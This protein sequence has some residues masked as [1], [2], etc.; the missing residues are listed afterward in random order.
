MRRWLMLLGLLCCCLWPVGVHAEELQVKYKADRVEYLKQEDVFRL[1]GNVE[2]QVRDVTIHSQQLDYD[3][4]HKIMRSDTPFIMEQ[5]TKEGKIQTLKGTSFRYDVGLRRVEGEN[6]YLTIPAQAEG[7]EIYIQ[8]DA[9]TAYEDGKRVLFTNG[10]YTTCNHF[11]AKEEGGNDEDPYSIAAVKR[12]ATHYAVQAEVLDFVQNQRVLAWN[13]QILTFENQAFWFPFWYVPLEGPGEIKKPDIDIGQNAVEGIFAKFKGY[14]RWNEYHDGRWY[15]SIIQK[16]GYGLGFQHDW[17]AYPNS[18]TRI[19][20]YGIPVTSDFL[21]GTYNWLLPPT[22]AATSDTTIQ[23]DSSNASTWQN[24]WLNWWSNKFMDHEFEFRHKQLLLPHMESEWLYQD[25]DLYNTAALT[26]SRNP[27]RNFQFDLRDNE[28][29]A[30]DDFSDLSTDLTLQVRQGVTAPQTDSIDANDPSKVYTTTTVAQSQNRSA[31]IAARLDKSNLNLR[32][33][34]SNTTNSTRKET[35]VNDQLTDAPSE[36]FGSGNENW[37]SNLTFS[38]QLD[39]KTKLNTNLIYNSIISGIS[40]SNLNGTLKKTLQPKFSLDQTHDW[41]SISLGYEDFFDLSPEGDSS[42]NRQVKKIPEF[43]LR[44]K[45]FFQDSFPVQLETTIGRYFEQ[46]AVV[47]SS[48]LNEIGRGVF[49]LSLSSKEQDLGLGMKVNY[50]GTSFEQRF[51]QTLDAEYIFTGQVNLKNNLSPFFIP[52]FSYQRSVIDQENNNSPFENFENLGLRQQNILTG[53]LN[54]VNLPEFTLIFNGGY[55]YLNRKYQPIRANITSAIGNQFTLRANGSYTPV[56]VEDKDVGSLLKDVRGNDYVDIYTG[57]TTMVTQDMVGSFIPN[58]GKWG[59]VTLG[60]R[61]RNTP[62]ELYIGNLKTFGLEEGIPNGFEIGNN[63]VFDPEQ[64]RFQAINALLRFK[65]GESWQWHTEVDLVASVQPFTL[66]REG[67][68]EWAGLEIPFTITVRKDLHDFVL[69][70]SWD[71]F[72]QQ[73][74]LNLALL[75][76][77]YSTSDL[78]GNVGSLNQQVNSLNSQ[79][80]SGAGNF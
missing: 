40:S 1:I 39:A 53:S 60:W 49:K 72:Y 64:G 43:K 76:F 58:G 7:Q 15:A 61:W 34:W 59:N 35:F 78:L 77:P 8:G 16:K 42:T 9:M 56:N 29:F 27:Q 62:N 2:L 37:N 69:T 36:Q 79:V 18:I 26:A 21:T 4:R 71:S 50:G 74:N 23:Q 17:I 63:I 14:Y 48:N 19:Y 33:N 25:K 12:R 80:Q 54:L 51:Y 46:A 6:V 75:A 45:P 41:G 38:T 73:F 32:S 65:L 44:F 52:S 13:A 68:Q 3:T 57:E 11:E 31:T 10:F 55:D 20:F 30:L 22:A 47:E 5:K 66:P 70:A 24:A 28:I 67:D